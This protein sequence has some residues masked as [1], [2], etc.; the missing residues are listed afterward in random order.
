LTAGTTGS[1]NVQALAASNLPVQIC[2]YNGSSVQGLNCDTTGA[3]NSNVTA[4]VGSSGPAMVQCGTSGLLPLTGL[5]V[6][7]QSALQAYINCG[8]NGNL[9]ITG[10]YQTIS[11]Y[12]TTPASTAVAIASQAYGPRYSWS[13]SAYAGE[14][15]PITISKENLLG[16]GNL[17]TVSLSAVPG[18]T[19]GAQETSKNIVDENYLGFRDNSLNDRNEK[20][21]QLRLL[22]KELGLDDSVFIMK[23]E[24]KNTK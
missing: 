6:G 5:A 16:S 11:A 15:A 8:T 13:S 19:L 18:G 22:Q 14:L 1:L 7:T 9:P 2:A 10:G 20:L 17:V 24:E 4:S 23:S 12:G 3:L 21:N